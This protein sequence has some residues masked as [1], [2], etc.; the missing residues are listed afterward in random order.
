MANKRY[1]KCPNR[2]RYEEYIKERK[3]IFLK[4]IR[5]Q[6][7]N[8]EKEFVKD[9]KTNTRAFYKYAGIKTKTKATITNVKRDD[10]IVTETAA[11]IAEQ[12]MNFF[13][14]CIRKKGM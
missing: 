12:L 11:K 7:T 5:L 8:F 1:H 4:Y 10:G 14:E 2:A 13:C 6:K 9:V 3:K